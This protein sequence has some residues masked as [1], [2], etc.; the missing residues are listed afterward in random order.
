MRGLLPLVHKRRR[1]LANVL[2]FSVLAG[3]GSGVIAAAAYMPAYSYDYNVRRWAPGCQEEVQVL[4]A[5]G[6]VPG[7]LAIYAAD[8]EELRLAGFSP[9]RLWR[10]D[11]EAAAEQ[12]FALV[13][14][15]IWRKQRLR[16]GDAI[17]VLREGEPLTVPVAGVWHPFHPQL[18]DDWLV[19]V[20]KGVPAGASRLETLGPAPVPAFVE[21]FGDRSYFFWLMLLA[22]PFTVYG[23][24][25]IAASR[26]GCALLSWAV[27]LW[28]GAAVAAAT[29][30]VTAAVVFRAFLALPLL[31]LLPATLG[32]MAA[33]YLLASVLLTG[34]AFLLARGK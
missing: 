20:G 23:A 9:Q 10:F 8:W 15:G 5:V 27:K 7:S 29:G 12:V 11:E 1:S 17:T 33:S 24:V 4:G 28:V 21:R 19:L 2:L 22:A 16:P 13:G 18:G 34:T 6:D 3:V 14:H 30:L 26:K 25:G 32:V 31:S